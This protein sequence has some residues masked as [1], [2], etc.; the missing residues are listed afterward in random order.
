MLRENSL[1]IR[2]FLSVPSG[3]SELL[4]FLAPSWVCIRQ[5]ENPGSWPVHLLSVIG[6]G[7]SAVFVMGYGQVLSS[8]ETASHVNFPLF[9]IVYTKV[10]GEEVISTRHRL[11]KGKTKPPPNRP[12]QPPLGMSKRKQEKIGTELWESHTES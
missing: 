8:F 1:V 3:L 7:G 12:D 2:C 9:G 11:R 6:R 4:A 10:L 5:K